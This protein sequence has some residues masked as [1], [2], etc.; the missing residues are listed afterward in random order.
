MAAQGKHPAINDLHGLEDAIANGEP[1][2]QHT[3]QGLVWR[4]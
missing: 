2:I 3:D 1:M 4:N